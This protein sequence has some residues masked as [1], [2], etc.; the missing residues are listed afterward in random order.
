MKALK[1]AM[2]AAFIFTPLEIRA[3][4]ERHPTEIGAA[5]DMGEVR[6]GVTPEGNRLE[7]PQFIT[8]TGVFMTYAATSN[9]K[10]DI[11]LTVGGLFWYGFNEES[12]STQI[13]E[14]QTR[15]GP[16]VGQAQGTYS[17]G[18]P[19]KPGIKLQFGLFP[20]KYN[21]DATNLGEYLYRSGTY[22]GTLSSG[23]WSYLN[24]ASY[25]AEG[26]HL[27]VPMF[28]GKLV[29]DF[30]VFFE[31]D[32][33]PT[34]DLTPGYVLTYKPTPYLE[35]AGGV[36]WAHALSLNSD[37][38]SPKDSINNAYSKITNLPILL[39]R[40]NYLTD[41]IRYTN[42]TD[43]TQRMNDSLA[44]AVDYATVH[45]PSNQLGYYTFK[46]FKTMARAALDIGALIKVD[47]I[48]PGDFKLYGEIAL[49]GVE[50]YPF[51]YD[52]KTE[53]MPIMFGIDIPTFKLLDKLACEAEYHKSRFQNNL[54][55]VYD[56]ELPLPTQDARS[57]S[58]EALSGTDVTRDDWHWSVYA[59]RHVI[60]GLNVYA[61][62]ASDN[63]R[64]ISKDFKPSFTPTTLNTKDWY[65]V[66]RLEFGLF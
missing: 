36:V 51:Y 55:V 66:V 49:L 57:Y 46:G 10:L 4:W 5:V 29:H 13:Y 14:R 9:K 58:D 40:G 22:P 37:R 12:I 38:L 45:T 65:Y 62:V 47:G 25:M 15:F 32:L 8:R 59:R 44:W 27:S 35:F 56:Q 43:A 53:R 23:G 54:S 7:N 26:V 52:K 21:P 34:G 31:R 16:G 19:S 61:Q 11:A 28:E 39:G 64:Q 18:D 20:Y 1:V 24:S 50:N 42:D 17:F 6:K 41:S 60:H 30:T 48:A 3:E 63:N 2:A 33:E